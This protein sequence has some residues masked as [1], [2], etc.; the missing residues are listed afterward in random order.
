KW[1]HVCYVLDAEEARLFVNGRLCARK[2]GPLYPELVDPPAERG[3]GIG[4]TPSIH[5]R[6]KGKL[7]AL[8]VSKSAR[9]AQDFTPAMRFE[10]DP[11]TLALYHCDQ[12]SGDK[13]IDSSGNNHHGRI[14]ETKWG[15]TTEN[16][17]R[18]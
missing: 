4:G 12:G 7:A 5:W 18:E 2:P 14:I 6:F 15:R 3:A 13:L 1:T 11:D 9:Y 17:E 8:R 10:N 16:S